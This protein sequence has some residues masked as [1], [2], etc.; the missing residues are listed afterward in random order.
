MCVT[1]SNDTH[2][3]RCVCVCVYTLYEKILTMLCSSP[4][5]LQICIVLS[6]FICKTV[7]QL[8]THTSN[9]TVIVV[10]TRI[11]MSANTLFK[12]RHVQWSNMN[13]HTC[14]CTCTCTHTKTPRPTLGHFDARTRGCPSM[15]FYGW[16]SICGS[17]AST[18]LT[19]RTLPRTG[20][21]D[22]CGRNSGRSTLS[23]RGQNTHV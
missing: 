8:H 4:H 20:T 7:T 11:Y 12:S 5:L 16:D 19:T 6:M 22:R 23:G 2:Q 10:L 15:R 14:T 18:P 1:T 13:T 21:L 9:N 3:Q 17:P